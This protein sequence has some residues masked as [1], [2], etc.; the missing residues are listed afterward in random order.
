MCGLE[1]F[2]IIYHRTPQNNLD[3]YIFYRSRSISLVIPII[4]K[5]SLTCMFNLSKTRMFRKALQV[6]LCTHISSIYWWHPH[7]TLVVIC[8][9]IWHVYSTCNLSKTREEKLLKLFPFLISISELVQEFL[10]RSFINQGWVVKTIT[11]Q[12]MENQIK[13]WIYR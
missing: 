2:C 3:V 10:S 5:L 11:C 7:S 9:Q 13:I 6:I 8:T 4:C 1:Q 12:I